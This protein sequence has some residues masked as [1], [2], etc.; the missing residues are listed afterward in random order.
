MLKVILCLSLVSSTWCLTPELNEE[1]EQFKADYVRD[2]KSDLEERERREIWEA[3][4]DYINEHNKLADSGHHTFWLGVNKFADMTNEE[5][6]KVHN[7]YRK[8]VHKLTESISNRRADITELPTEVDWRK[9]GYVGPVPNEGQCGA[10]W[11]FS[12]LGALEGQHFK[13]TGK[14]VTL[15]AQ[16]LMD[17]SQKE[18]NYGCE[19]G[20]M[21]SA[22]LYIKKNNGVDTEVSYPYKAMNGKCQFKRADVGATLSRYVDIPKGNEQALQKSIAEVGPISTAIDASNPS[23]QFYTK[24]VY[25]EPNCKSDQLDHANVATGYGVYNNTEYYMVREVFGLD[26]GMNGYIMMSR[27]RNNNCGIATASSYPIV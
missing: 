15:S 27:N 2:Y 3:N 18:G 1:W 25:Y 9:K 10:C 19:G 16:N 8:T 13:K 6:R 5:F 12:A 22:F 4:Y 14:L 11:A 21:D 26:Y 17:C 23:F 24:G 20:L 7:T